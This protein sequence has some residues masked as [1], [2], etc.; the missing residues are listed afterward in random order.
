MRFLN[1]HLS[2]LHKELLSFDTK[3]EQNQQPTI[4]NFCKLRM[5]S[6]TTESGY[7]LKTSELMN[8]DS[9]CTVNSRILVPSDSI[10]GNSEC[11]SNVET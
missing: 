2:E 11:K 9:G 7:S 1:Q 8:T 3:G 6:L 10:D 4:S 5:P